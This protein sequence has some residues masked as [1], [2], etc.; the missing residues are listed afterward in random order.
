MC[1]ADAL[2]HHIEV[3]ALDDREAHGEA[4]ALL[5]GRDAAQCIAEFAGAVDAGR[6]SVWCQQEECA[7]A[8]FD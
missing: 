8:T 7:G 3:A 4:P 2:I 1:R 5:V 6:G